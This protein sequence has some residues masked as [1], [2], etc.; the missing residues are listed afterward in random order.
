MTIG[1]KLDLRLFIEGVEVPVI[2]ASVN[3]APNT[4]VAA[5]IQVIA[6]DKVHFLYPRTLV[7]LFFYDFVG[8]ENPLTVDKVSDASTLQVTNASLG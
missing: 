2:G 5:S 8:A 4:P 6:T 3:L 1:H 7:H